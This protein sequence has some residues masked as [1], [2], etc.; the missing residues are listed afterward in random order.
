MAGSSA[1]LPAAFNIQ[2]H[3]PRSWH[4]SLTPLLLSPI[5]MA[6][7]TPESDSGLSWSWIAML[8]MTPK[9]LVNS[10]N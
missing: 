9:L 8:E 2:V 1:C 10:V 4:L 6:A 7:P 3:I 5:G